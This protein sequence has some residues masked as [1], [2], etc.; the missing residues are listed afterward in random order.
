VF[1]VK[2]AGKRRPTVTTR[3]GSTVI[4]LSRRMLHRLRLL[5]SDLPSV[6]S[7]RDPVRLQHDVLLISQIARSGGTLLQQLFDSHPQVLMHP[8]ELEI[9][10]RKQLWPSV[11]VSAP[12]DPVELF[13]GLREP[14]IDRFIM[15]GLSPHFAGSPDETRYAFRFSRRTYR[16]HFVSV[17]TAAETPSARA[18]LDAYFSAFWAAWRDAPTDPSRVR[19]LGG[20]RPGMIAD[21]PA[22]KRFFDHYPE[23]RVIS[24]V[25]DPGSWY[26]SARRH[27]SRYSD[28]RFA[29]GEWSRQTRAALAVRAARPEQVRLVGFESLLQ[30]TRGSLSELSRWLGLDWDDCFLTPTLGG[31]PMRADSS[32]P[33][34]EVG[35]RRSP[36]DRASMLDPIESASIRADCG[37]L[38]QEACSVIDLQRSQQ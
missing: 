4:P 11:D 23:G 3:P 21:E 2:S 16:N 33:D 24:I 13:E 37:R 12:I 30:D 8:F 35:V 5:R 10:S 1:A 38:H 7:A 20:F 31:R 27:S 25:R 17:W 26:A 34:G 32:F 28:L 15:E 19:Y 6:P 9:G 18:A 14:S 22:M 36:V 29:I